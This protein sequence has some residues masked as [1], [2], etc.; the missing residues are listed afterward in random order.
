MINGDLE[1]LPIG[2]DAPEVVNVVVEVSA[3]SRNKYEYEP[4]LGTILRDRVLPGNIR[5][6][7]DYGFL[8]S[9]ESAD[10]EPL[11]VMVAAHDPVFPGCMLKA[12]V[13]GALEM[14]EAGETEYNIFAV[15][16]D[17]PRFEDVSSLVDI[18]EQNLRE[19][20][21]F[22]VAFKR[23]E[24]DEEAEVQGWC[25]LEETHQIIRESI[26]A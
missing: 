13:L 7:A 18:P 3:G 19:I 12:R 24:G 6:P 15:P 1:S 25:G 5:Y 10:G 8:P 11:D 22:F 14:K 21:Q 9:T 2:E 20:E 4:E 17:D 26:Q 16:N 23:L